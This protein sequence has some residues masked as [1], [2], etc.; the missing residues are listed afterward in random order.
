[1]SRQTFA[2]AER[3]FWIQIRGRQ[4]ARDLAEARAIE[5]A[6]EFEAACDVHTYDGRLFWHVPSSHKEH[7]GATFSRIYR[8]IAAESV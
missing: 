3:Y 2:S 1:M 7:A 5:I 6:H 4:G 8:R